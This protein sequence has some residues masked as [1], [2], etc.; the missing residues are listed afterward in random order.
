MFGNE[1]LDKFVFRQISLLTRIGDTIC[2]VPGTPDFSV[3]ER[4]ILMV[5]KDALGL[6]RTHGMAQGKFQMMPNLSTDEMMV[7]PPKGYAHV[8]RGFF[9]KDEVTAKG[10]IELED[11]EDKVAA[12]I[13]AAKK[14]GGMK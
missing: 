9:E 10:S 11:F 7:L 6:E 2:V 5:K 1:P 4:V 14:K 8:T 12:L 3:N 13:A